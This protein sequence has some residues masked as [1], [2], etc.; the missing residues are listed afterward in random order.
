MYTLFLEYLEKFGGPITARRFANTYK[1]DYSTIC[2]YLDRENGGRIKYQYRNN[3]NE[4][5]YFK[6]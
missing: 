2:D 3:R 6:V 1:M 5:V 4:N